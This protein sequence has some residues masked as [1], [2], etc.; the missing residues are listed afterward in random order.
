MVAGAQ[1]VGPV[2]EKGKTVE[3]RWGLLVRVTW[4]N[5]NAL[6]IRFTADDP[7]SDIPSLDREA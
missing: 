1:S 2:G 7:F 4:F 3:V 6:G 5:T